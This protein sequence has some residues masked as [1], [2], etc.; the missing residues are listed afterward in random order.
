MGLFERD[1]AT[2]RQA[3]CIGVDSL[4]Q[5]LQIG[6][7]V[8]KFEKAGDNERIVLLPSGDGIY[9]NEKPILIRSVDGVCGVHNGAPGFDLRHVEIIGGNEG[10]GARVRGARRGEIKEKGY[11]SRGDKHHRQFSYNIVH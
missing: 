5:F 10:L 1:L 8:V 7:S 11:E 4:L 3:Q 6:Q 2:F 9:G